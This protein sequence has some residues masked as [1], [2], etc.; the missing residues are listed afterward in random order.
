MGNTSSG[1]GYKYRGRG[2][3]QITG[4]DM[5]DRVGKMIGEDLVGNPDL[6]NKPEIAAKIIPAF[7]QLKLKEK[8]LNVEAYDDIDVVN[9]TVGGADAKSKEQRKVLA[10]AYVNELGTGNQIDQASKENKNLK[11]TENDKPAPTVI[12][13]TTNTQQ[14]NTNKPKP[15]EEDDRSAY[16]KRLKDNK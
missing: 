9:K 2:F 1:D 12:N 7:F 13:N 11:N 10:A 15:Q 8:K 5:Y 4:K 3:I 6:A 14:N 16:Q